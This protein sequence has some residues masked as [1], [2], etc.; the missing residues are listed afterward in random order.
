M[1]N[2]IY[3]YNSPKSSS[4]TET[5][6]TGGTT[7][8]TSATVTDVANSIAS[9]GNISVNGDLTVSG[10]IRGNSISSQS[11]TINDATLNAVEGDAIIKKATDITT[12]P[13]TDT[14]SVVGKDRR[15]LSALKALSLFLRKDVADTASGLISF[16][17]GVK[18]NDNY[19]IDNTG[20]ATLKK[21]EEY[22]YDPASMTGFSINGNDNDFYTL[23]IKNIEVWGKAIFHELEIRRL[24]YVGGNFIFS[25]AGSKITFVDTNTSGNY[26]CFIH[27]DDGSTRTSNMWQVG[28]LALCQTFN[29]TGVYASDG[30]TLQSAG[31]R[32]YWRKVIEI[33][34]EYIVLS[35]QSG[36]YD[37]N[38][39]KSDGTTVWADAPAAEDVI[40]CVGN[41]TDQTRMNVIKISTADL[42][43]PEIIMY[44]GVNSFTLKDNDTVYL[45]PGGVHIKSSY[46][47]LV[48]TDGSM[49]SMDKFIALV[50]KSTGV[51]I[52]DG[53]ITMTAKNTFVKNSDGTTNTVFTTD[54]ATG[55][56]VMR[57]DY[58]VANK[59]KTSGTTCTTIQ[60]GIA[61]FENSTDKAKF[62][63]G[64]YD[65]N[66]TNTFSIKS[67]DTKGNIAGWLDEDGWHSLK[68][69]AR[70]TDNS[71]YYNINSVTTLASFITAG[72]IATIKALDF[73]HITGTNMYV[74]GAKQET[75]NG[76]LTYK[77]DGTYALTD[78]E[79]QTY[80]G[81]YYTA[82]GRVNT[83]LVTGSF[84]LINGTN[85]SEF[86]QG[87]DVAVDSYGYAD[88][89]YGTYVITDWAAV[90]MCEVYPISN[91]VLGT[92]FY[93]FYNDN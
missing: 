85:R 60:N 59:I 51:S 46:F 14:E 87:K 82:I 53:T 36:E 74:F 2:K 77:A 73:A 19:G 21:V 52:T 7:S 49:L 47:K 64:M 6:T 33:A 80:N 29:R 4:S 93:I 43:Y 58:I 26:I 23:F 13:D 68:N 1:S 71:E 75:V 57:S 86:T 62:E 9:A 79:A 67:F 69:I 44:E 41:A 3:K 66:G 72:G 78:N 50:V 18:F 65:N 5:T 28:D 90:Y 10:K 91:G 42:D 48:S 34:D 16:L 32:Y 15:V 63:V 81:D 84:I 40:C 45:S 38:T 92:K 54:E 11:A 37:A 12:I 88:S 20:Q 35:N 55:K 70:F 25:P 61:K 83:N 89:T 24:S 56:T 17:A 8:S 31:N 30:T 27:T 39:K 22:N 76:V